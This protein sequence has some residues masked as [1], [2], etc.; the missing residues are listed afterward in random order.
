MQGAQPPPRLGFAGPAQGG[1][2]AELATAMAQA[3]FV[4]MRR[5]FELRPGKDLLSLTRTR[6]RTR[7]L[8]LTLTL[9]R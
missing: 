6:T 5:M 9:T 1:A 8:T 7:T 4:Q 3:T 2:G